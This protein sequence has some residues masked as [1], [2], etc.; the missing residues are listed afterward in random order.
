[1]DKNIQQEKAECLNT[2]VLPK[3]NCSNCEHYVHKRKEILQSAEVGGYAVECR[4]ITHPLT[5]CILRGFEA[6]SDQPG[7]SQT[8]NK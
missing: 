4:N 2:T 3:Y 7:F 5:D 6:H 8:L 1:M